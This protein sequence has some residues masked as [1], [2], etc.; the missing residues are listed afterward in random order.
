MSKA[1]SRAGKFRKVAENLYRYSSNGI[2]YA[3]FRDKGKLK[4][5]SLETTDRALAKRRLPK[6]IDKAREIDPKA[7]KMSLA[8]LLA[9][10]ENSLKT[11]D[12]KTIDTRMS[13]ARRFKATWQG[14]LEIQV[15]EISSNALRSWLGQHRERLKKSSL[16]EYV[17]FLRHLFA[18]AVSE[19]V[20]AESPAAELGEYKREKPIRQTPTWEQYEAIVSE[21]RSQ[22]LSDTAEHS[23]DV[24][25]FRA[26]AGE[27]TAETANLMGEHVD[28][29]KFEKAR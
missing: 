28:F 1:H 9:I 22:R 29:D 12:K 27:G 15:R 21:I 5:K 23:A 6:E 4:W 26:L 3:V 14:G 24:V 19:R 13:I 18:A 10:Y 7:A 25:E 17:R 2:Y 11:L 8:G 20:I 16:N